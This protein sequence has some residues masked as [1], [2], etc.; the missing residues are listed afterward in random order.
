MNIM[1]SYFCRRSLVVVLAG[2]TM[3]PLGA[4]ATAQIW[5]N[6]GLVSFPPQV[7]AVV[8]LNTGTI[9]NLQTLFPIEF[10][11]TRYVTNTGTMSASPGWYFN[12]SPV[13]KGY[14]RLL[15]TFHNTGLVEGL[16]GPATH[17]YFALSPGRLWVHATNLVNRGVLRVEA[18]GWLK[19]LGTNINLTRGGLEVASVSG[20][21]NLIGS[22]I[23]YPDAG[24][25]DNYWAQD[26]ADLN[27]I[28]LWNG[29]IAS[30]PMHMVDSLLGAQMTAFTLF[31]PLSDTITNV[32]GWIRIAVTNMDGSTTNVNI[33]T[34]IVKQAVFV[35]M[36]ENTNIQAFVGYA[37]SSSPTN[38]MYT[39][40]VALAHV[41]TNV[42]TAKPETNYIFFYDTLASEPDRGLSVNQQEGTARPANYIISR[43]P[44]FMAGI[45]GKGPADGD[46]LYS[47]SVLEPGG[48]GR[49][50]GGLQRH[51]HQHG[52]GAPGDS[53]RNSDECSRTCADLRR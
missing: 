51:R 49:A 14:R 37:R 40:E 23:F 26:N 38:P 34:N 1:A 20:I 10:S 21:G 7:D 28:P 32:S 5:T 53:C 25:Y 47:R 3:A 8:A 2:I 17:P 27:T 36:S 33:P 24:I 46:F 44:E 18:N 48:A 12:E 52:D 35:G 41:A 19:L 42:I 45:P 11:N 50:D 22:N 43:V 30:T 16:D 13:E 6:G 39:I 15:D 4:M 31:A 9:T 29:F